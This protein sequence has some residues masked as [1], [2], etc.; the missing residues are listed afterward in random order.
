MNLNDVLTLLTTQIT[1]IGAFV[2]GVWTAVLPF[3]VALLALGAII[4]LVYGITK[5]RK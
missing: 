3:V 4:G 1:A 2:L 5:L